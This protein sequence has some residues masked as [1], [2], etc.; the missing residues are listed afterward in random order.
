MRR[1][2]PLIA[3]LLLPGIAAAQPSFDCAAATTSVE[4]TICGSDALSTLDRDLGAAYL[5]V[6]GLPGVA[7]GQRAWLAER[8][9]SC[10]RAGPGQE[11]CLARS[12]AA[13]LADLRAMGQ[14]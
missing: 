6:G 3:A 5:R 11:G 7:A 8:N 1:I 13:R 2:L 14:K 4:Q 9:R 10:G 12:Y